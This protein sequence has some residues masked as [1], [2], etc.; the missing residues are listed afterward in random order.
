MCA[1]LLKDSIKGLTLMSVALNLCLWNNLFHFGGVACSNA[2][3]FLVLG[4]V[5]NYSLQRRIQN[6]LFIASVAG[7]IESWF[8]KY[9]IPRIYVL[10][11][12]L[13]LNLQIYNYSYVSM[14]KTQ[15]KNHKRKYD[16][17]QQ[18]MKEEGVT[19]AQ[20]NRYNI[21]FLWK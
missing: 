9:F 13:F 6:L 1:I 5:F 3:K 17:Q 19:E 15:K 7:I 18:R 12:N 20:F 14:S 21:K 2:N 16:R 8:S 10:Y 11:M 4:L